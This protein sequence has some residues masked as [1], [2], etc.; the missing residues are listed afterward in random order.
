MLLDLSVGVSGRNTRRKVGYLGGGGGRSRRQ[1]ATWP[2]DAVQYS[3][4]HF[5]R[6]T[7]AGDNITN[8]GLTFLSLSQVQS[9]NNVIQVTLHGTLA[10]VY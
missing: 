5:D 6:Q 9:F 1:N 10:C 2:R 4:R 7:P 3:Y 8:G